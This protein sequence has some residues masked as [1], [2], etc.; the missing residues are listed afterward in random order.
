M[1]PTDRPSRI[2]VVDA[3]PAVRALIVRALEEAG[4]EVV[5]VGDG[6][7]GLTAAK[8][9]GISFDLVLTNSY[10]PHMSGEQLIGHLR[11]LF[12]HLPILHLDDLAR[13]IGPHAEAVPTLRKP[14]S[15][16]ALLE[17]VALAMAERP[18]RREA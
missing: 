6:E 4:Y 1:P 9:A 15:I 8:T 12:P 11:R 16:G 2:L 3:E 7:A 17:S 13:P 10:M 18:M 5:A 14:F